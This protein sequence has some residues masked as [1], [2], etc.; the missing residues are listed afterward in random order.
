MYGTSTTSGC[1]P[2]F[3]LR[4]CLWLSRGKMCTF[5]V[6]IKY[7]VSIDCTP[8]GAR[9]LSGCTVLYML[10]HIFKLAVFHA[11]TV[12][13][14]CQP[15]D[16]TVCPQ[17]AIGRLRKV[18]NVNDVYHVSNAVQSKTLLLVAGDSNPF[19]F[20]GKGLD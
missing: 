12:V 19:V 6:E 8:A 5:C 15:C 13:S 4:A 9:F 14:G 3:S 18:V 16:A 7:D 11:T 1:S 2:S 20:G 17:L 10:L